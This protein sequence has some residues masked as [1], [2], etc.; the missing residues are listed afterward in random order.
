MAGIITENIRKEKFIN[1][2]YVVVKPDD[3]EGLKSQA[4]DLYDKIYKEGHQEGI[5]AG[6]EIVETRTRAMVNANIAKRKLEEKRLANKKDF[7]MLVAEYKEEHKCGVLE[8]M[9]A[10]AKL[11][12]EKH[13]YN[14]A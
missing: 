13:R 1:E 3:L 5:K 2:G 12:P 9:K 8:A 7:K 6:K 14:K 10:I 11:H 4:P